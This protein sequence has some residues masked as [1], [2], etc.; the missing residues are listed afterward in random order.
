MLGIPKAVYQGYDSE[1]EAFTAYGR[2]T[3]AGEKRVLGADG[4]SE[5]PSQSAAHVRKPERGHRAASTRNDTKV[6]IKGDNSL[7]I[8]IQCPPV[9]NPRLHSTI[10]R[11]STLPPQR[12]LSSSNGP[13]QRSKTVPNLDS[14]P[15]PSTPKNIRGQKPSGSN[16]GRS[17]AISI[18]TDCSTTDETIPSSP[19]TDVSTTL[20]PTLGRHFPSSPRQTTPSR[21]SPVQ[22]GDKGDEDRTGS[23]CRGSS[24]SKDRHSY[25]MSSARSVR[26]GKSRDYTP[27][28]SPSKVSTNK[29][30][31]SVR[32]ATRHGTSLQHQPTKKVVWGVSSPNRPHSIQRGTSGLTPHTPLDRDGSCPPPSPGGSSQLTYASGDEHQ[33]SD[34][35]QSTGSSDYYTPSPRSSEIS[36]P[37]KRASSSTSEWKGKRRASNPPSS[38]SPNR[39]SPAK[40]SRSS[41]PS[42]SAD[43]P[44]NPSSLSGPSHKKRRNRYSRRPSSRDGV[45]RQ[46]ARDQ[47]PTQDP[48]QALGQ[49]AC[50]CT[51]PCP[52]CHKPRPQTFP[53]QFHPLMFNPIY[54]PHLYFPPLPMQTGHQLSHYGPPPYPYP[55]AIPQPTDPIP[56]ISSMQPTPLP[57]GYPMPT[58]FATH[59]PAAHPFRTPPHTSP[60]PALTPDAPAPAPS[61]TAPVRYPSLAAGSSPTDPAPTNQVSP[62]LLEALDQFYQPP[63]RSVRVIDPSYDPRSP[64][65]K[66]AAVPAFSDR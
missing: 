6:E 19:A 14:R 3:M 39:G 11:A 57:S 32:G 31:T 10:Q 41:S 61:I 33:A 52:S 49:D 5:T 27:A 20:S 13:V 15:M 43:S 45:N 65:S 60:A 23:Q 28:A 37:P 35:A 38:S 25:Q 1:T 12:P 47:T 24:A 48:S 46:E 66:K 56:S 26:G 22:Q 59:P 17:R 53:P 58:A 34:L 21:S 4:L 30:E 62:E 18:S 54:Y 29:S 36:G 2:A 50:H 55:Y 7:D 16:V 42:F 63:Q 40:E 8:V 44:L 64:Y 51:D 9:S